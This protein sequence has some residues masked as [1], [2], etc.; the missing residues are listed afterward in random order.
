MLITEG[1]GKKFRPQMRPQK[2]RGAGRWH[3]EVPIQAGP[4]PPVS[5]VK[6]TWRMWTTTRAVQ[7]GV[8]AGENYLGKHLGSFCKAADGALCH[9]ATVALSTHPGERS[10]WVHEET[11]A[12][13]SPTLPGTLTCVLTSHAAQHTS[14][15]RPPLPTP[16]GPPGGAVDWKGQRGG[17][18]VSIWTSVCRSLR[19][20]AATWSSSHSTLFLQLSCW[21]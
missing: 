3:R 1:S 10:A 7:G 6:G 13:P 11:W 4:S 18:P 8:D 20:G 14:C 19:P 15:C 17:G 5:S 21:S 9:P 12:A 16:T 2:R